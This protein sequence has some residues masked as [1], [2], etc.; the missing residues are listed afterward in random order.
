M[1]SAAMCLQ[2]RLEIFILA[3]LCQVNTNILVAQFVSE[4]KIS[5]RVKAPVEYVRLSLNDMLDR[6]QVQTRDGLWA[7]LFH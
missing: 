2:I 3:Y 7:P 1:S 4:R 5:R 6:G